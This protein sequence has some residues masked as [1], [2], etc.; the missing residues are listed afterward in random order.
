LFYVHEHTR[1]EGAAQEAVD[2]IS[3]CLGK[4]VDSD[5]IVRS[6][7]QK[8]RHRTSKTHLTFSNAVARAVQAAPESGSRP[9]QGEPVVY[10]LT[11]TE[12]CGK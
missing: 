5:L 1:S 8:A 10:S 2:G 6:A 12:S 9:E 11:Q 7:C 4:I 3:N